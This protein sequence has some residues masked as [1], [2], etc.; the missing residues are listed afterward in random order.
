MQR[1]TQES[2]VHTATGL[3]CDLNIVLGAFNAFQISISVRGQRTTG[4]VM[5][6]AA[7]T[8]PSST[9]NTSRQ[10][11]TAPYGTPQSINI[12]QEDHRP[13][14]PISSRNAWK[15]GMMFNVS[16]E[17][18]RATPAR[19]RENGSVA[20]ARSNHSTINGTT[21]TMSSRTFNVIGFSLP[22]AMVFSESST[23]AQ[24]AGILRSADAA[25]GF[26]RRS[27]MQAVFDV[28]E[29]QGRAAGL[30]EFMITS[31]LNQLTVNINYSPLDCRRVEVSPTSPN[32]NTMMMVPTCVIFSN[33]VTAL[34]NDMN[35]CMLARALEP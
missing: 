29:Q 27:V 1:H 20:G 22:V 9:P 14:G 15:K 16:P 7:R 8:E 2:R 18:H 17:H 3:W 5:P 13:Y 30:P 19:D 28:L 23:A 6:V 24:V 10:P 31:V 33:T 32:V 35:M 26:V 12:V 21:A 34:C 25:R 4:V 11:T